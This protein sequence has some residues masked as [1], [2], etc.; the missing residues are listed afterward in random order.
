M[1]N[2]HKNVNSDETN[3]RIIDIAQSVGLTSTRLQQSSISYSALKT[4]LTTFK[5]VNTPY[6][7]VIIENGEKRQLS[8]KEAL[9]HSF[10]KGKNELPWFIA[11]KFS[12]NLRNTKNLQYRSAIVL[13]LDSYKKDITALEKVLKVDL[14]KYTY[15]AYSTASHTSDN[16]KIRIF[17]PLL[18]NIPTAEYNQIVNSFVDTLTFKLAIDEASFKPNQFMFF[19]GIIR[20]TNLPQEIEQ[21]KYEPWTLENTSALLNPAEFRKKALPYLSNKLKLSLVTNEVENEPK[22]QQESEE[23]KR[24]SLNLTEAEIK[25]CLEEYPASKLLYQEWLEVLQAV[26]HYYNG[27]NNG[28]VVIDEWSKLDIKKYNEHEI[29]NKWRSFKNNDNPLT[30]LTVLKRI[31]D[32]RLQDFNQKIIDLIKLLQPNFRDEEINPVMEAIAINCSITEAE[33]YLDAIKQCTNL[34]IAILRQWAGRERRKIAVVQTAKNK[35][36]VYPLSKKLPPAVFSNYLDSDEKPKHTIENLEILLKYYGIVVRRNEVSNK[37]EISIPNMS[38]LEESADNA[39]LARLTGLCKIND[40]PETH[41]L[42]EYCCE[43]GARNHYNPISE[44]IKSKPWDGKQRI[45]ELSDTITAA[46]NFKKEDK[47]FFIKKWLISVVAAMEEKN[48][49][50]SK[51]VLVFQGVQ[52]LGKTSWFKKLFPEEVK[53]YFL[54]GATLDPNNKDSKATALCHAIVELGELDSTMK[55]DIAAIKAFLSSNRDQFRFP[56]AKRDS[57]LPRRTIFCASVNADEFLVD[58]TGNSRFWSIP[59]EKIDYQHNI[60]M[61][62]LW[63]EVLEL[64]KAGEKWWL[65]R[66]EEKVLEEY[67]RHHVKTCPYREMIVEKYYIPK[68]GEKDEHRNNV[69]RSASQILEELDLKVGKAEA[70]AIVSAMKDLGAIRSSYS[71]KFTVR[72]INKDIKNSENNSYH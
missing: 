33:Y 49:V 19:S 31:K 38:Y 70:N 68:K 37:D 44:W 18:D 2:N 62:Q 52:S 10:K 1:S 13:D 30:F 26:H 43:I 58:T 48:G 53:K 67:N 47:H 22:S 14:A 9:Q 56:Y 69:Q 12:P 34:S 45:Y 39:T 61:Q 57:H 60:D 54:E 17:L 27:G 40:I 63:A 35:G 41:L 16:P 7:E 65:D 24:K 23:Q 32:K 11:G 66:E 29:K 8:Q 71:R 21:Q 59:V 72:L 5:I 4:M 20:I 28:L 50:F 64:Y 46:E 3:A 55:K 51:G 42:G 15:I 25:K 6:T 36:V